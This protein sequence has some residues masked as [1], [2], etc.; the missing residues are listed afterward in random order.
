MH[1]KYNSLSE[2]TRSLSQGPRQTFTLP[3]TKTDPKPDLMF[4][5]RPVRNDHMG[6]LYHA[7]HKSQP[8]LYER[9]PGSSQHHVYMAAL[10]I[11]DVDP[12]LLVSPCGPNSTTSFSTVSM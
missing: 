9:C 10:K 11:G 3:A 1:A 7:L 12:E 5:R 2:T 6:T 4:G 8:P